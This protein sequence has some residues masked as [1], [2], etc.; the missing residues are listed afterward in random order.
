MALKT[1]DLLLRQRVQATNAL[2][3]HMAE[4]GVVAPKGRTSITKLIEV[5]DDHNDL[6]LSAVARTALQ[7]LVAQI[8]ALTARVERLHSGR[9]P[10]PCRHHQGR[11]ARTCQLSHRARL[12]GLSWTDAKRHTG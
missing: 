7:E 5:L 2:R 10:D 6:S 3:G 12:C 1:R 8:Q 11:G 9:R 4:L